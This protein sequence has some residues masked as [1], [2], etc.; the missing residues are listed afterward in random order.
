MNKKAISISL[1]IFI[2]TTAI[3][4]YFDEVYRAL[5]RKMILFFNS[6]H[7]AFVGKNFHIFSSY[8]FACIFGIFC[9]CFYWIFKNSRNKI[10]EIVKLIVFFLI[11]N[12]LIALIE[13]KLL[14]IECT[15]CNIM[16]RNIH[17]N[18]L[19]YEK[20]LAISCTITLLILITMKKIPKRN[21]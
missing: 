4:F 3:A 20:Y 16:I 15:A 18:D 17:Y 21:S 2:S 6:N 12:L 7:I 19:P 13:S 5:I 11:N 10:L 14:M 8:T 9:T 1:L